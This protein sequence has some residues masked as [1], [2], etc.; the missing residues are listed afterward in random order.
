M[1]FG[2]SWHRHAFFSSLPWPFPFLRDK[3]FAPKQQG[4]RD[5]Q[6]PKVGRPSLSGENTAGAGSKS[7]NTRLRPDRALLG[8][9]VLQ[10]AINL[11][12]L[13][14]LFD[15][16]LSL[17]DEASLSWAGFSPLAAARGAVALAVLAA[18]LP[19]VAVLAITPRAPKRLLL[20]LILFT[21]W[22]GP[23][24][25][26]P[27]DR[28]AVPHL[29][30]GIA[31]AQV[32]LA[33]ALW[34]AFCLR[35]GRSW[36]QLFVP[37]EGPDFS[38]KH[39]CFAAPA[40]AIVLSLLVASVLLGLS[41]QI[42]SLTSGYVRVRPDGVYLVERKFES[43]GREVRLAAMIHVADRQFYESFLSGVAPEIPSVVLVEGVTDRKHLLGGKSLSYDR[44][45]K[46]LNLTPQSNSAFSQ[47]IL[48]GLDRSERGEAG[49]DHGRL[50]P[51]IDFRHA[52]V[53]LE[54]FHPQTIAL[55]LAVIRL[56]QSTSL[57]ELVS[58]LADPSSP[59]RDDSAQALA[60]EDILVER[61][62]RLVA[63]IESSLKD[64][65][66]VIVPWGAMHLPEIESWLRFH[67]F[68]KSGEIER[69][70]LGFWQNS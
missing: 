43:G 66:R 26:F 62:R 39:L 7:F 35:Q 21:W 19:M 31:A 28:W 68:K 29:A 6:E 34:Y 41:A 59:L 20:A 50:A 9:G 56:F 54:T 45:A 40:M 44:L 57:P 49:Q 13:A 17:I 64:Y 30:L 38:W 15:G 16:T 23:A 58:R 65:R 12:W 48:A 24:R 1:P 8:C 32:T 47:L 5:D 51:G 14:F 67:S 27:L 10:A 42:E 70:A 69:R 18:T 25:A 60:I 61:N 46:L 52:D 11:F 3:P 37:H 53:D 2:L 33:V 55:L 36:R 63:E 4:K 22:A